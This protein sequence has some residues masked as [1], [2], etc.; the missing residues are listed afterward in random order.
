MGRTTQALAPA[1]AV[2]THEKSEESSP[3]IDGCA[4][5]SGSARVWDL[6]LSDEE[7]KSGLQKEFDSVMNK[8]EVGA[9]LKEDYTTTVVA[10]VPQ[11]IFNLLTTDFSSQ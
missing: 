3:A 6:S 1:M 10:Q 7:I 9:I 4:A 8:P 11:R 5:A 2:L